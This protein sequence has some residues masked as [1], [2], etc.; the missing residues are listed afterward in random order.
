MTMLLLCVT[1]IDAVC[2]CEVRRLVGPSVIRDVAMKYVSGNTA[3]TLWFMTRISL[4]NSL[5]LT[6]YSSAAAKVRS[7]CYF[8]DV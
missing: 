2:L 8:T 1:V 3:R 6:P 7:V 4:P 5:H